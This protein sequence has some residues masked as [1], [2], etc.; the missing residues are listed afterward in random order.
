M[1]HL[2][3]GT[4][5][6]LTAVSMAILALALLIADPSLLAAIYF[7]ER[8]ASDAVLVSQARLLAGT[9]EDANGRLV[10]DQTD[11]PSETVGGI[12]VDAVVVSGTAVL[13]QTSNQPLPRSALASLEQSASR[14]P[15]WTDLVDSRGIHRRAYAQALDAGSNPGAVLIVSR[16]TDE[17][18]NLL[19][20]ALLFLLAISALLLVLGGSLTYWLAGRALA[21]V[22]R[23]AGLARSISEHDLHRRVDISVPADELGELVATFNAM[24]ARLEES[25][26]SLGRF[27]ADASHELRAPL[28][29]MRSEI[30]RALSRDRDGDE[31]MA[32]LASLGQD[33]DHLSRLSDQ[34]LMLARADAGALRP[35]RQAVDVADFLH[36]TAARW[37]PVASRAPVRLDVEAPEA[38]TMSADPQLLRRVFDNLLDNAIRYAP[39][40]STVSLA[41]RP[42]RDG[43]DLEVADEGPGVSEEGRATLFTRFA[44][45]DAA[46]TRDGG[47]AGL[48]LALSAAIARVHG[49]TLTL[50]ANR[51]PGAVFRLHL[52][53]LHLAGG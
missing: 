49:G 51:S 48:G 4:R 41:G 19:L 13:A 43:W 31:Y 26:D 28:S 40:G 21:P 9:L 27:T 3:C 16:S 7:T 10:L 38:G 29:V 52:P 25:F 20:R 30:D 45:P 33:V 36:E 18:L 32:A 6:R 44:K 39:A 2:L 11:I 53:G 17:L 42:M 46:R 14:S 8:N 24:L 12:A 47:G 35:N 34:L 1:S 50:A 22:R 15:A 5:A 23:I 37:E